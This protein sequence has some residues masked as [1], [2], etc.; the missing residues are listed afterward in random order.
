L[1]SEFVVYVTNTVTIVKSGPY[2]GDVAP[3]SLVIAGLDPA[4]HAALSG[5]ERFYA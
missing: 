3:G 2:I 4:I 5:G 1:V